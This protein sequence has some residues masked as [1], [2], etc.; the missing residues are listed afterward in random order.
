MSSLGNLIADIGAAA[1]DEGKNIVEMLVKNPDL[2]KRLDTNLADYDKT[3]TASSK[4]LD[5]YI[6]DYLGGSKTA[7]ARST[8]EQAE[9]DRY[10]NGDIE[11]QLAS[12]RSRQAGTRDLALNRS[13]DYMRRNL[14]ANQIG[15]GGAGSSYDRQL[16]MKTGADMSLQSLLEGLAQERADMDYLNRS[17]LALTGQRTAMAD[18]LAA[19][20]LV[21]ASAMKSELGWNMDALRNILGLDQA[22]K[23]YGIKYEPSGSEMAGNIVGDVANLA[24]SIYSGGATDM[25]GGMFGGGQRRGSTTGWM[26]NTSTGNTMGGWSLPAAGYMPG[27]DYGGGYDFSTF[28]TLGNT[29]ASMV[30]GGWGLGR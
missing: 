4:A 8:Q 20:G 7:T 6:R 19:R 29:Y 13:L 30:P 11:R 27:V 9:L 5:Q 2:Q 15:G 3:K 28:P 18:A 25:L 17:K 26:P 10:Y 22:N 12:L 23:F 21:P 24:A 1:G 14:S 16:A